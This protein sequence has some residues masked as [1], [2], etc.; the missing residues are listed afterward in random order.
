MSNQIRTG[1]VSVVH[2]PN[3]VS[4]EV[5][6]AYLRRWLIERGKEEKLIQKL[7]TILD[8]TRINSRYILLSPEQVLQTRDFHTTN[9]QYI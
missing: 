7:E 1:K 5:S 4:A 9:R 2:P 6:R 3:K 8:K